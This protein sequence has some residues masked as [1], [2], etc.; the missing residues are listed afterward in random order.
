MT[1][2]LYREIVETLQ[3]QIQARSLQAGDQI[4]TEQEL[5]ER[6]G[7]SR[8]TSARAV[9]ELETLGMV[10]RIRGKGSF[11]TEETEWAVNNTRSSLISLVVPFSRQTGS[12]YVL[13]EGMESQARARRQLITLHNSQASPERERDIIVEALEHRT[14]G[15]VIYPESSLEN[16]GIF[17]RLL[18][19]R[20]PFVVIDR[21]VLGLE[22]P[23]V[24]PD[25][26]AATRQIVDY[27]VSIGHRRI[28]YMGS[29][30]TRMLSEQDRFVGYCDGLVA[31]GIPVHEDHLYISDELPASDEIDVWS[32]VDENL[33][34]GH[35]ALDH[36]MAGPEPPTAVVAINDINAAAILQA[37]LRRGIRVPQELS[38]TGFDDLPVAS[39]LEVPLT[40][41]AQPFYE[42][43]EAAVRMLQDRIVHPSAPVQRVLLPSALR[44]RAS[45]APPPDAVR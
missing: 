42:I 25:N 18:V 30:R 15:L 39:H 41:M 21:E 13:L 7:V 23:F 31:A 35:V 8:I 36:L 4:P 24:G 37:A 26:R 2:S 12:G 10:R 22:A 11:V 3:E 6:F 27:L 17:T 19:D 5:S 16:L 45:T 9:R 38:I 44:V 34:M 14:L 32:Q 29:T 43:G 1:K 40:T 28:A 20:V 33:A